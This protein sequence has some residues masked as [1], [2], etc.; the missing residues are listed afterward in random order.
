MR[1]LF[2]PSSDSSASTDAPERRIDFRVPEGLPESLPVLPLRQG[3]VL[4]G[5]IGPL[6]I[7][8]PGSIAAA[9]LVGVADPEQADSGLILVAV[10]REPSDRP[11]PS[12]LLPVAVL[13][14]IID[15]GKP[16]GRAPFIVV[17]GLARVRLD[18]VSEEGRALTARF[19]VIERAWDDSA[20]AAEGLLRAVRSE[21]ARLSTELPSDA[22]LQG[23]V[24][25]ALP[26]HLW[27]DAVASA[28]GGPVQWRRDLLLTEDPKVRAERLA[29]HIA[30]RVEVVAAEKAVKERISTETQ[31]HRKEMILRQQLKAIQ[32][33]LGE[34]DAQVGDL[35][36]R[37]RALV[38][39]DEVRKVV[40]REVARLARIRE[41]SPER[42]V[43]VDWLEWIA[44]LPWGV[45]TAAESAELVGLEAALDR[46]HY[47]L[48]DVKK[49]VVEHLAVRQLA[50]EGRADVLLLVGPPGVG[51]TSIGQ[52]VAEAT[53][54]ELVRVALGGVRD[55]AEIRGHRRTYVGA[56]PG[57]VVE[58]LRR[59]GAQDPVILLDELDKL[60]AGFQGDPAAAL[61]EL[62]DPEQN[63]AFTDRYL[64]VPLD[65]SKVLFIAT[66]NDLGRVPAPLRDRMEVLRIDG[67]TVA[68]K[69]RI[70]RDHLLEKLA[71]NAG[72]D[73]SDVVFTDAAIE[74][75]ITGWT[76]EAGVRGL[77]RTLGKV[78][79]AAAVRKARGTLDGPLHVDAGDLADF[80]GRQKFHAERRD[81]GPPLPGI[82]TGLAW[83]P[84]GGDVLM[85]EAA[86]L[87]GSGRL[88]LTGQLGDVM[89]ESARAALTYVLSHA[90]RLGIDV[91]DAQK[92]D[93]HIHVP[94][95]G[96]P[97]DGPSAGVTMFTALASL[98]SNRPV[99]ASV[100]MTGEASLRGRVL[101]VGGIRS[102]VLAA[103][104]QGIQTI[105]LPRRN[106]PDLED[107]PEQAREELTF[108]L[109]DRMDE[110][111]DAALG[112]AP[113]VPTAPA[114]AAPTGA[115]AVGAA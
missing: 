81:E 8:R 4:P 103:H 110:V 15:A 60:G 96:V 113:A 97:K 21:L 65:M 36:D 76:R 64:E 53:G 62:L 10:Q 101:P 114:N 11:A 34:G 89:K 46:S 47:G 39:P 48:D 61:L 44:A 54:R 74:S 3:V 78:Y 51:K 63:H 87:P 115:E 32:D 18:H 77:Q 27:L 57:R 1:R 19:T 43:A 83:T 94:A 66:A 42:A 93:I 98:L 38:L 56:R 33:E 92:K 55:E 73:V 49:Q 5:G 105:V 29:L 35:E 24:R 108:V 72:V 104:R 52:A 99:D 69:S 22:R 28:I 9:E 20:P 58:G 67:Y 68:E 109:V 26:P 13:A 84:V 91:E 12:D 90:E 23:L 17:A 100:A 6:S 82:A 111:L 102:K 50:G 71:R 41:G 106:A 112:A 14:R 85:V 30:S 37:I 80:L 95:G 75:A 107:V 25:A 7:G 86:A 16:Q 88:V 2:T 45:E 59:A 70:V 40:D 79:R 31:S